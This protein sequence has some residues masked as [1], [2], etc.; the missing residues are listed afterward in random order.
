VRRKKEIKACP[1]RKNNILECF[2]VW[3]YIVI[4]GSR[5]PIRFWFWILMSLFKQILSQHS[6]IYLWKEKNIVFTIFWP[7]DCFTYIGLGA[8]WSMYLYSDLCTYIFSPL[9]LCTCHGRSSWVQGCQMVYFHTK[10]RHLGIF[11]WSLEW[12]I[13][14]CIMVIWNILRP[15]S[16]FYVHLV[17]F[18]VNWYMLSRF[19]ILYQEKS[20]NPAWVR[21]LQWLMSLNIGIPTCVI[22]QYVE[23]GDQIVF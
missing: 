10:N 14:I 18:I 20:G 17:Y 16:I 12:K 3:T 11:S 19:G 1:P 21:F 7:L 5:R 15:F 4:L 22:P 8:L 9:C 6:L 13:L 23:Q 2:E